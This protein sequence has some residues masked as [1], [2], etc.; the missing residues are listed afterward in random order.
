VNAAH[1]QVL[2]FQHPPISE[3]ERASREVRYGSTVWV[4]DGLKLQNDRQR[5][6]DAL[7]FKKVVHE[8]PLTA[9]SASRAM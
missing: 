3:E 8:S 7:R 9:S 2:E 1:G 4:V 6:F 5:L